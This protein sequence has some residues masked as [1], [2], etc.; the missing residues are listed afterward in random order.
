M[1]NNIRKCCRN[2]PNLNVLNKKYLS[3]LTYRNSSDDYKEKFHCGVVLVFSFL[4][5]KKLRKFNDFLV[6]R[7]FEFGIYSEVQHAL[8]R[9]RHFHCNNCAVYWLVTYSFVL[10]MLRKFISPK[11]LSSIFNFFDKYIINTKRLYN[12]SKDLFQMIKEKRFKLC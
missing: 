4:L 3:I 6:S 8:A 11:S 12:M 5:S 7:S 1:L 10:S 2:V 9:R